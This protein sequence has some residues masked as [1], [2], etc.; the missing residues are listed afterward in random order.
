LNET[1]LHLGGVFFL[2]LRYLKTRPGRG[3]SVQ[4]WQE[5]KKKSHVC[6]WFNS[7]MCLLPII[8]FASPQLVIMRCLKC[9]SIFI[10][11]VFD[12]ELVIRPSIIR[13]CSGGTSLE[14]TSGCVAFICSKKMLLGWN[15]VPCSLGMHNMR[16]LEK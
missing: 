7:L 6:F 15:F 1:E 12:L 8:T 14:L 10:C 16:L 5:R 13:V 2:F 11:V 9:L 4:H 3:R